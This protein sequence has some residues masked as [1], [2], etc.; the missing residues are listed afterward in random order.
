MPVLLRVPAEMAAAR[1]SPPNWTVWPEA[2]I[3][4]PALFTTVSITSVPPVASIRPELLAL[5]VQRR[6]LLPVTFT[7][8]DASL[9]K[10]SSPRPS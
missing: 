5:T 7:T 2:R 4:P 3:V 1:P 10:L 8:P 6:R 9:L